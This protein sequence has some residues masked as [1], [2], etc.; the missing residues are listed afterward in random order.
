MGD[1][2]LLAFAEHHVDP[3]GHFVDV[4][5]E[6]AFEFAV[7]RVDLIHPLL[8]LADDRVVVF[9]G[10]REV[11]GRPG[12]KSVIEPHLVRVESFLGLTGLFSPVDQGEEGPGEPIGCGSKRL[13][14]RPK[15]RWGGGT[16]GRSIRALRMDW[17]WRDRDR[18]PE[19]VL[20]TS[21]RRI[22]PRLL[23]GA[24][25]RRSAP[26]AFDF[27]LFWRHFEGFPM[28]ILCVRFPGDRE[29]TGP[30]RQVE[31]GHE[32][33]LDSEQAAEDLLEKGRKKRHVRTVSIKEA[34]EEAP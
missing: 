29:D 30:D 17:G 34:V 6:F 28:S 16:P 3:P 9:V 4:A 14:H 22:T 1:T 11:F 32:P 19:N 18:R 25:E 27:E 31:P 10:S 8:H 26:A 23:D 21:C 13:V 33:R 24:V 12:D 15:I 5:D 20:R 2:A 7:T